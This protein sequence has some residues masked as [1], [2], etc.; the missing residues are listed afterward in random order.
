VTHAADHRQLAVDASPARAAE[1][2]EINGQAASA[3]DLRSLA[4]M[5]YGHFTSMQVSDA[6]V[7]GLDLHVERLDAATREL[8][9]AP[10]DVAQVRAFMRSALDGRPG[11]CSLRVTVFSRSLNRDRLGVRSAPDVLT[12]IAP[13]RSGGSTTPV[14]LKS[15]RHERALPHVK[16]VG[17][18]PLFHYRRLAQ[19]AG[20]GDALFVT[21]DGA[22]SEASVW[23]VGFLD[24]DGI[25]WPNAPALRGISMQLVKKGLGA[26]GMA[27]RSQRI[28][29]GELSRYR[30]AFL[31]NSSCC[32]RPIASIDDI[33]LAI[34]PAVTALIEACHASNPW[35]PI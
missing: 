5:N 22:V 7:R 26:R 17:T 25:V 23:N 3:D 32:V 28:S 19:I 14:R 10:L 33:E 12:T 1:R 35:Q 20:F 30:A 11:D 31:T 21:A 4:L 29:L 24:A 18:F 27:T 34:D 15:F 8:F 6:R 16:H 9:G 13:A 2:C